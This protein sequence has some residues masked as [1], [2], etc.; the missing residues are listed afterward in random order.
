[1]AKTYEAML[2]EKEMSSDGHSDQWSTFS[3]WRFLDLKM[4]KE[5]GNLEKRLA[6]LKE[7]EG[8]KVFNITS[9]RKHEGVSTIVAN[10]A[11]YI[12]K[13]KGSKKV[14]LI[15]TN[16]RH[17][18]LHIAFDISPEPGLYGLF[19]EICDLSMAIRE[20]EA[21]NIHIL[22]AGNPQQGLTNGLD[23]ENFQKIVSDI[24]NQYDYIIIDSAPL[25]ESADSLSSA[26]AA[27][28]TFLVVQAHKTQK[29]VAD[30]AKLL[31]QENECLIG[32][33]IFNRAQHVIPEKLYN[34]I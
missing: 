12:A 24:R 16:F 9:S 34:I 7:K 6:F 23:E 27:D 20:T 21:K 15:D 5:A 19:S 33:I 17:P 32:G 1:M 25:L 30:K 26:A 29:E 18:V 2:R 11:R 3:G 13:K 31:L 8:C 10:L 14:L 22:P 4:P 28:V